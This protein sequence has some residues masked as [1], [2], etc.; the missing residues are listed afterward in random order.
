MEIELPGWPGVK[1]GEV[2]R[3]G[4]AESGR[5]NAFSKFDYDVVH[6]HEEARASCRT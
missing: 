2:S 5:G 3:N 6:V 1:T 4:L